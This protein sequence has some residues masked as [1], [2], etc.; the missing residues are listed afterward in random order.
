MLALFFVLGAGDEDAIDSGDGSGRWKVDK[1]TGLAWD[2]CIYHLT[3]QPPAVPHPYP[4]D[5][6]HVNIRFGGTVREYTPV[7]S[8]ADWEAGRIDLLVKTY[9]DGQVSKKFAMLRQASPYTSAEE[10]PCWALT[11]APALTLTLPA[12]TEMSMDMVAM[13]NP[14]AEVLSEQ[15]IYPHT[16]D[17]RY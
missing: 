9:E 16:C 5:A 13:L 10:Q 6:W 3:N 14:G 4:N 2:T 11:S 8:A 17:G 15:V 7:S 12:L 1:I